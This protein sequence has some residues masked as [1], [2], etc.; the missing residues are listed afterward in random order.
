MFLEK[1]NEIDK[2]LIRC[3]KREETNYIRNERRNIT[4]HHTPIKQIIKECD[5]Q[6][7]A[8]KFDTL[9]KWVNSLKYTNYK[10]SLKKKSVICITQCLLKKLNLSLKPS[11]KEN[12]RLEWF[13]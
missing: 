8:H 7:Y 12:S 2:P 10:N 6:I 11:H 9:V 4:A 3:I 1:I 13:Y 5:K